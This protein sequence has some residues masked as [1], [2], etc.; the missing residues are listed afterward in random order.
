MAFY[1]KIKL[2]YIVLYGIHTIGTGSIVIRHELFW[3]D[4]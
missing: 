1:L 2:I 4:L 3:R